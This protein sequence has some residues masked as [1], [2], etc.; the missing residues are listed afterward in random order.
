MTEEVPERFLWA[1]EMLDVQ[2]SD[3]LLE[4]G[5]GHGAAVSLIC[6]SL[7]S[8]P[9]IAIDRS[10]SMIAQAIRRNLANI[11]A[12][13]VVFKAF[14]LAD[15]DFGGVRFDKVFAINVGLFRTH[16][17]REAVVLRRALKPRG[18]LYLFQQHPSAAR[19]RVVTYDLSGALER[20][21]FTIRTVLAKGAG[22]SSMT[23]I[24]A[25]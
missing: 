11:E 17:V 10:P 6:K 1:A 18:A 13:K 16:A 3:R 9:I 5:C 12:G 22:A 14:A 4:I 8:A 20:N 19:T 23:C 24:V 25:E 2:P 7:S 21:G 15:A